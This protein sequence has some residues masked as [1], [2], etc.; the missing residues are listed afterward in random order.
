MTTE[1]TEN[2]NPIADL[3][4]ACQKANKSFLNARGKVTKFVKTLVGLDV[5]AIELIINQSVEGLTKEEISALDKTYQTS[6]KRNLEG[7]TFGLKWDKDQQRGYFRV[8]ESRNRTSNDLNKAFNAFKKN[9]E[10][11]DLCVKL[12]NEVMK[13]HTKA[14]DNAPAFELD[15]DHLEGIEPLNVEEE[16]AA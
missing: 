2:M 5:G 1:N 3:V 15:L 12:L 6:S 7:L 13:T 10:D 16:K 8:P 14:C 4:D 11:H 9:P